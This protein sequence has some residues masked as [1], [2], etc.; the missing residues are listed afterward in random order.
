MGFVLETVWGSIDLGGLIDEVDGDGD[1]V[2]FRSSSEVVCPDR[3]PCSWTPRECGVGGE[4]DP[5][6]WVGFPSN[7]RACWR[8]T[9]DCW[10]RRGEEERGRSRMPDGLLAGLSGFVGSSLSGG[11]WQN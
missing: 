3:F 4:P 6:W 9:T 8:W 7:P 10:V 11:L 5:G 2:G 1:G